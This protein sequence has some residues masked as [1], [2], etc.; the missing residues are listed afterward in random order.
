[1]STAHGEVAPDVDRDG[2]LQ[3]TIEVWQPLSPIPL[4]QEDA[5]QILQNMTGFFNL[6][7][8]WEAAAAAPAAAGEGLEAAA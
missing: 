3:A 2:L 4:N 7:I 5:R 6:L 1:M 8:S